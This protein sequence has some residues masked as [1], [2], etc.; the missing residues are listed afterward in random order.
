MLELNIWHATEEALVHD[1]VANWRKDVN[2]FS[3]ETFIFYGYVPESDDYDRQNLLKPAGFLSSGIRC[4]TIWQASDVNQ[5]T[6][7]DLLDHMASRK[8]LTF[9]VALIRSSG[10]DFVADV[11]DY[12]PEEVDFALTDP[13][14]PVKWADEYLQQWCNARLTDEAYEYLNLAA[15]TDFM[16]IATTV[17]K[18]YKHLGEAADGDD[19]REITLTEIDN[20]LSSLGEAQFLDMLNAID[21]GDLETVANLALRMTPQNIHG[22][23]S[24]IRNRMTVVMLRDGGLSLSQ[25]H[26]AFRD[27]VA[28]EK[29]IAQKRQKLLAKNKELKSSDIKKITKYK[30]SAGQAKYLYEKAPRYNSEQLKIIWNMIADTDEKAKSGRLSKTSVLEFATTLAL[31]NKSVKKKKKARR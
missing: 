4:M 29:E 28:E 2:S 3:D 20:V 10:A 12:E 18:L 5:D 7:V 14:D 30:M 13:D 17:S 9:H 15:M 19:E 25:V 1:D 22:I 21:N 8:D 27:H 11:Y 23:I 6:L 24:A 16:L 31:V 26:D